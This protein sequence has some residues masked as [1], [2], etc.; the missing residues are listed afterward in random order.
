[1]ECT[2]LHGFWIFNAAMVAMF[3][4]DLKN[5][6]QVEQSMH[7]IGGVTIVMEHPT[8]C[9]AFENIERTPGGNLPLAFTNSWNEDRMPRVADTLERPPTEL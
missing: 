3:R 9:R 1:M 8:G 6:G 4:Q 7:A 2:L 5:D